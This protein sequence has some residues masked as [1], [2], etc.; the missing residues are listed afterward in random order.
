MLK[1]C[2]ENENKKKNNYDRQILVKKENEKLNHKLKLVDN[3]S[4]K[5]GSKDRTKIEKI[6]LEILN[7]QS[8]LKNYKLII[9][10]HLKCEQKKERLQEMILMNKHEISTTKKK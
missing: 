9:T 2:V 8:K 10:E 1:I 3:T 5:G 6:N 7:Q 4:N